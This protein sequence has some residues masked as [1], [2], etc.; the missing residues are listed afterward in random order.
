MNEF[1]SALL[2]ALLESST[3]N[4]KIVQSGL[5]LNSCHWIK[6]YIYDWLDKLNCMF[7]GKLLYLLY[8]VLCSS[9]DS[10]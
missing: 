3:N 5:K 2:V 6:K 7:I 4:Q 9:I 8:V 1:K 10:I